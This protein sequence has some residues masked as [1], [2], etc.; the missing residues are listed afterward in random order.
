MFVPLE[1]ST[2]AGP[3]SAVEPAL[4]SLDQRPHAAA[5][6]ALDHDRIPGAYPGNKGGRKLLGGLGIGTPAA[7][8]QSLVQRAHQ[9][10]AGKDN[11]YPG[12]VNR[13]RELLV[14]FPAL[15]TELQHVA[16]D[17]DAA[18][19]FAA[20]DHRDHRQRHAHRSWIGVVGFIDDGDRALI[21]WNY[22]ARSP[23]RLGTKLGERPRGSGQI[24]A[25][26]LHGR[27]TRRP[28]VHDVAPGDV[29]A[30]ADR[31]AEN[32][33]GYGRPVGGKL[34][35][36]HAHIGLLRFTE[37]HDFGAMVFGVVLQPLVVGVVAID[38]R[39]AAGLE[40]AEDLGLGIGDLL[41]RAEEAQM[42]RSDGRDD[43]DVRPDEA[44]Q[45]VYFA[46]MVHA[47]LEHAEAG[48]PRH[49]G[50]R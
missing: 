9:L 43:G 3:T 49:V 29:E 27:Q 19:E 1:V 5:E 46:R 13:S 2:R 8:R 25:R 23:A 26:Q 12:G 33:G 48:A 40:A 42:H 18:L 38:D 34:P 4:K 36:D 41:D 11:I 10:A 21:E 30:V 47:D 50:Q 44:R 37:A 20:R 16:E 45:Q 24:R 7:G 35:A 39:D 6:R 22:G 28:I 14:Q 32:I 15:R 17:R 31:L